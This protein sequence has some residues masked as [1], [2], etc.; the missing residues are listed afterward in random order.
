[1]QW[2]VVLYM[3]I[4]YICQNAAI[5]R[6]NMESEHETN[7][8]AMR[9]EKANEYCF[10]PLPNESIAEK[11]HEHGFR[12]GFFLDQKLKKQQ[13]WEKQAPIQ[14]KFVRLAF[15]SVFL[16]MM[17]FQSTFFD[18]FY[19]SKQTDFWIFRFIFI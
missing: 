16:A 5:K 3:D 10:L 1:M 9:F 8:L 18:L 12:I 4:V 19:H 7:K 15:V 6:L 13:Q 11:W 14:I 17:L 2:M